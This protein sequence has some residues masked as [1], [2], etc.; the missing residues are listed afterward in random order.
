MRRYKR[1]PA[2]ILLDAAGLRVALRSSLRRIDR[3]EVGSGPMLPLFKH[4]QNFQ[5]SIEMS[6]VDSVSCRRPAGRLL[7]RFVDCLLEM[8]P[9]SRSQ[10][11]ERIQLSVP[12]ELPE[13]NHRTHPVQMAVF[14]V[15]I[16][17][18]AVHDDRTGH[19]PDPAAGRVRVICAPDAQDDP[20]TEPG[21][22]PGHR[23]R[24]PF[25]PVVPVELK[26]PEQAGLSPE[27]PFRHCDTLLCR[28][29][30]FPILS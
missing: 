7:E 17:D 4:H 20:S 23:K 28:H 6:I 12:D 8:A 5:E 30:P 10:D 22:E 1:E 3:V 13:A 26:P 14:Q 2:A 25:A 11:L 15:E 24:H 27:S 9:F 16:P 19:D 21:E 18:V 29:L